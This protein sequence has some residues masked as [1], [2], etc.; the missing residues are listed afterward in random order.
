MP[1][2]K[3]A[4]FKQPVQVGE[5]IHTVADSL[6]LPADE[7]AYANDLLGPGNSESARERERAC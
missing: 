6:I 3:A 5:I 1:R 4:V 2:K 7:G